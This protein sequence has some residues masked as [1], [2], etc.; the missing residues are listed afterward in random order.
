[1]QD[2]DGRRLRRIRKRFT[3]LRA[4]ASELQDADED[5]AAKLDQA[6]DDQDHLFA[7]LRLACGRIEQLESTPGV[8]PEP[9]LRQ[10]SVLREIPPLMPP[11]TEI[12]E[13]SDAIDAAASEIRKVAQIGSE[14]SIVKGKKT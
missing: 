1:M 5:L 10:P 11:Y 6:A 12:E 9:P 7:V 3:A 8:R 14:Y 2:I 13:H 4:L